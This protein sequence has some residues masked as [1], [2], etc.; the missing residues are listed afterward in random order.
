MATDADPIIGNW[1]QLPDKNQP[2]EVISLDED[3]GLVA[4]HYLDGELEEL[5]LDTWY[6]LD[7]EPVDAPEEWIGSIDELAG[8]D[9]D[10]ETDTAAEKGSGSS[11]KRRRRGW[12]EVDEDEDGLKQE[13]LDEGSWGVDDED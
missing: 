8:K 6:E 7:I 1:Y 2:F 9:S 11:R 4:I 12:E 10:E 5:D 13:D 3:I